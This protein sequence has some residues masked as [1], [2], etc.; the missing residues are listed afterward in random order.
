M[1]DSSASKKARIGDF[2][3]KVSQLGLDRG[4]EAASAHHS[5]GTGADYEVMIKKAEEEKPAVTN[6]MKEENHADDD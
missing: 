4:S 3:S 2:L 6:Q 1:Q 5:N